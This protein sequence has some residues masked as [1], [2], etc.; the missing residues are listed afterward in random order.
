MEKIDLFI[1]HDE[2]IDPGTAK[3]AKTP[4]FIPLAFLSLLKSN[5][6]TLVN[7]V[8]FPLISMVSI[9]CRRLRKEVVLGRAGE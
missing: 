4:Y 8:N 2:T 7:S 1:F 5:T 6:L 3:N 9:V